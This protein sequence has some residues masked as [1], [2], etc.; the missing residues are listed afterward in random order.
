M[1]LHN[2]RRLP[3]PA[4]LALSITLGFGAIAQAL[5]EWDFELSKEAGAK[6]ATTSNQSEKDAREQSAMSCALATEWL[7]QRIKKGEASQYDLNDTK[8]VVKLATNIANTLAKRKNK[9]ADA[10]QSLTTDLFDDLG[11]WLTLSGRVDRKWKQKVIAGAV[12]NLGK[13]KRFLVLA[14]NKKGTGGFCAMYALD[15]QEGGTLVFDPFAG[16][17]TEKEDKEVAKAMLSQAKQAN[18]AGAKLLDTFVVLECST[19]RNLSEIKRLCKKAKATASKGYREAATR[20]FADKDPS[21]TI[22]RSILKLYRRFALVSNGD[23][24]KSCG[25]KMD[26]H[27][28]LTKLKEALGSDVEAPDKKVLKRFGTFTDYIKKNYDKK[29]EWWRVLLLLSHRHAMEG[30]DRFLSALKGVGLS[31]QD[32]PEPYLRPLDEGTKRTKRFKPTERWHFRIEVTADEVRV[33]Q[34]IVLCEAPGY[35]VEYKV[36]LTFVNTIDR[37]KKGRIQSELADV[38]VTG[39]DFK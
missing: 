26:E 3:W 2:R 9:I 37:K 20:R 12:G 10:L 24:V 31:D 25:D 30:C 38:E 39:G 14:Y 7:M 34:Q 23:E 15:R 32:C 33:T 18:K 22:S 29:G 4:A 13:G 17:F 21:N 16:Q 19:V 27:T 28:F 35:P 6:R 36:R 5:P 8:N 1:R 11:A